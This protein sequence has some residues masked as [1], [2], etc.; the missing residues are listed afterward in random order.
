[1][2]VAVGGEL[3]RTLFHEWRRAEANFVVLRNY[4]TLPDQA[5]NDVDILVN[6]HQ[7]LFIETLLASVARAQNYILTNCAGFSLVKD[8]PIKFSIPRFGS[9]VAIIC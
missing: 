2:T 5:G 4:A 8:R 9:E 7:H 1:M 6:A 3:I